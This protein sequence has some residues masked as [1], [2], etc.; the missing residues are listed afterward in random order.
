MTVVEKSFKLK[1]LGYIIYINKDFFNEEKHC[2]YFSTK[3]S[4]I[5]YF[6]KYTL[7]IIFY[8]LMQP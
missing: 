2:S 7:I 5:P 1:L 4:V 6:K 3:V 8:T